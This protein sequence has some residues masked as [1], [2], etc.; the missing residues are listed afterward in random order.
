M[1]SAWDDA[2]E[3]LTSPW[4]LALADLLGDDSPPIPVAEAAGDPGDVELGKA[5]GVSGM[6]KVTA[7]TH[8]ALTAIPYCSSPLRSVIQE[9]L[10]HIGYRDNLSFEKLHTELPVVVDFF[11]SPGPKLHASKESFASILGIP[12]QKVEPHLALFTNTLVQLDRHYRL[13]VEK[14]LDEGPHISRY[15]ETPM[16]VKHAII[17]HDSIGFNPNVSD[18]DQ[19]SLPAGPS[20]SSGMP[21][22]SSTSSIAKMFSS[23]SKYCLL[24]RA[25]TTNEDDQVVDSYYLLK[26]T[27]LTWNQLLGVGTGACVARAL[28]ET[29]AVSHHAEHFYWK[30]RVCTTDAAPTNILCEKDSPK[31]STQGLELVASVLQCA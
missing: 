14:A 29:N 23:E 4:D 5:Q 6:P 17:G 22:S 7:P 19:K 27:T 2:I 1:A 25:T 28:L 26:G 10:L 21:V 30:T 20:A 8:S 11:V 3:Q 13:Q 24:V 12:P 15:D 9:V 18:L 16:K 31:S